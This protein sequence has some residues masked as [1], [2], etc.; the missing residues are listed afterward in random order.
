MKYI[1]RIG[2]LLLPVLL[3]AIPLDEVKPKT[4]LSKQTSSNPLLERAKS[5]ADQGKLKTAILN[6]GNFVD[7]W[8]GDVAGAWGEYQWLANVS[9][10]LGVPG[11]DKDGDPYP[12]AM[13]PHPDNPD[14]I[15]YWGP[16]VSESWLDRTSNQINTDWDVV[17]GSKGRTYSGEI[18]AG[19]YVGGVWTDENDTWPLLATSIVPESWPVRVDEFGEE[20]R[21]WPGW[22]A[23]DTDPSSPTYLQEVPGRFVSDVDIYLEFDDRFAD[24]EPVSRFT[25]YPTGSK[26]LATVHS[27]G[28]A[29][30]EDIIFVT[31]KVVN[32]SDKYGLNGGLGYDYE[33]VYFGFYFDADMFSSFYYGGYRPCN[34]NDG[35]MMGYNTEYNYA[36]I[37]DLTGT[38]CGGAYEFNA[39]AAV[40]LLDTPTASDTVWLDDLNYVAPGEELG[41]TDWHWFDWYNRPGVV[42]KE[43]SGGPFVGDARTPE[44]PKKEQLMYQLMSGDTTGLSEKEWQ[45]Y[46]HRDTRGNLN[47][48]FDSMEG[49][50]AQFPDGLDCVCMMSSGPFTFAVGDTAMFSFAIIMGEDIPDLNRNANM[51]QIMYDLRY[52]GFSAPQAPTVS[53]ITEWDPE[54]Q[55]AAVRLVWDD[56]AEY[57]RDIVTGYADFQG[58]RVYKSTDGGK[59][60]GTKI[61]DINQTH[62][63]W[64]PI[65]QYDLSLEQDLARYGRDISG[66][67]PLAPWF[68]L[69]ENTG[70]R[71]EYLDTDVQLGKEYTYSVTAYDIGMEPGFTIEVYS[72][73]ITDPVSGFTYEVIRY[74]T[75]WSQTS[76]SSQWAYYSLESL[77]SPKG[78][79][80]QSPQFIKVTPT[81]TPVD[82][83]GKI[84]LI[85]GPNTIGNT[86]TKI[87]ITD[88]AKVKEHQYKIAISASSALSTYGPYI[89]YP[90]YSVINMNTGDTLI[91]K[92]TNSDLDPNSKVHYRPIFDGL[93]VI[94]S[95]LERAA[96]KNVYWASDQKYV[97]AHARSTLPYPPSA[98]YA[99]IFGALDEVLDTVFW[100]LPTPAN[101][102]GV[103]FKAIKLPSGERVEL[104]VM[105][106][107]NSRDGILNYMDEI[108][109]RESN[110]PGQPPANFVQ[111]WQIRFEWDTLLV[112]KDEYPFVPGD[113]LFVYTNKPLHNGDEYT[114][115]AADYRQEVE[116]TEEE[117]A[118]IR[119][120]PN[121][122]IVSAQWEQSQYTKKLLFM[123][124]PS[125]CTITI[126]TLTGEY[127]NTIV[128]NNPYDNSAAWNLTTIN[129]QEVA[130]GLYVFTVEMPN[131]KKHVGKFA[132]IR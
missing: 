69:G 80:P 17:L 101:R 28:R 126:F 70:L 74:D 78:T 75:T 67:D 76:T 45:W 71:H 21:F 3:L 110:V 35:D 123:N 31:M 99:V 15:I 106:H 64:K 91:N 65:A 12:W 83:K 26:V 112:A 122:Y 93:Q 43:G 73:E 5:Y 98:D 48:H 66:P 61:F 116:V 30:A 130:P 14:S 24:R 4:V 39:Y 49:L 6:Y 95:N 108:A 10:M 81:R 118:E 109:F 111:T 57:S 19:D 127:V 29:Y 82:L 13:R 60:W 22:F 27:Y 90:K 97:S 113:T 96:I 92:H 7:H 103:P 58:Y 59:S 11:K 102:V 37:Y 88:P 79:T 72:E 89:R 68:S 54:T 32:E 128:H 38:E 52:Q 100:R 53:A 40:K 23:T 2:C 120:V 86:E 124:L 107:V 51:A 77:E 94:F 1:Q 25:G 47:P 55:R 16:S 119:V 34:T 44:S 18:T 42:D 36:Y 20:E 121:P 84:D 56:A 46:F 125:E 63:G 105:E 85:P 41:L 62:A 117:L 33:D 104:L 50:L 87:R 114:F 131:G 132:I 8:Q 129:R 9:F 115:T